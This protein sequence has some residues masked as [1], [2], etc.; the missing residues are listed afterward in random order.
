MLIAATVF[1]FFTPFPLSAEENAFKISGYYK[2]LFDF[3]KTTDTKEDF[4]LDTNR[5]RM[6]FTYKIKP[7]L[8]AFASIDNELLVHDFGKNPDFDTIRQE[9]QRNLAWW[10]ADY[11]SYDEEHLYLR[12]SVY[13]A[14]LKYDSE[15][16]DVVLGKQSIDWSRMRFYAPLDLFTRISPLALE[17]DERTG[18]D[19]INIEYSL[20]SSSSVNLIA[21]PDN[22]PERA[23]YGI[24][25]FKKVG[26]Y[27][28]FLAGGEFNKNETIG[29][30]FDGY[31]Y[32]AGFRGELTFS[33]ADDKRD[34]IR[35]AVGLDYSPMPELYLNGEYFYN[36]AEEV[37]S[38]K[39]HLFGVFASY[40]I[41]PLLKFEKWTI[42]DPE[43]KSISF[44]P[45]FVYNIFTNVDISAGTELF[46]GSE[47]SEY[48]NYQN[49]Y[50]SQLKIYY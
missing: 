25:L 5:L 4:Y 33:H 49:V 34:F 41:T 18:A 32:K 40:E 23:K 28:L 29:C 11:V 1:C 19:A 10:D 3:S 12:H 20:D 2:N 24:R 50:Y 7:S 45:E 14:Y 16:L 8:E 27:D 47:A 15:D 31:L 6:E 9:D 26:D 22:D 46:W 48:G 35:T 13:R 43:G 44:N 37:L 39:R 42:C 30:G 17:K 21:A 36:G 38:V